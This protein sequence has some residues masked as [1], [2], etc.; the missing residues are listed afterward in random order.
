[1]EIRRRRRKPRKQY[2]VD[3]KQ[4]TQLTPSQCVRAADDRK[5]WKQLVSQAVVAKT[6]I[7]L[8]NYTSRSRGFDSYVASLS[9]M[10]C[11]RG[12]VSVRMRA[13]VWCVCVCVCVCVAC[14]CVAC[15]CVCVCIW[16]LT[17]MRMSTRINEKGFTFYPFKYPKF[18]AE[19]RR[20]NLTGDQNKCGRDRDHG[21]VARR[22]GGGL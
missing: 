8:V 20:T 12:Y 21:I 4:W 6:I 19:I 3:I 15:A 16:V 5:R 9:R 11:A 7:I 14:V 1:M 13:C 18:T 2:I 22:L 17:R 10:Q